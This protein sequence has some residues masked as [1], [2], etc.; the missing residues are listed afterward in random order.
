MRNSGQYDALLA[1][2]WLHAAPLGVS[3]LI[4]AAGNPWQIISLHIRM[5]PEG[6]PSDPQVFDPRM[7]RSVVTQFFVHKKFTDSIFLRNK[8]KWGQLPAGACIPRDNVRM[9][10]WN[11]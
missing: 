6:C 5:V 11:V 7:W 10:G 3:P 2:W 9:E 8:A 1:V 4:N